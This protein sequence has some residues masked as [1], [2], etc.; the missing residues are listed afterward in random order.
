MRF[1]A[2]PAVR[3][4]ERL[5][6]AGCNPKPVLF[7]LRQELVEPTFIST[8]LS[9]PFLSILP[10][11]KLEASLQIPAG[12]LLSLSNCRQPALG[13]G[14]RALG[15]GLWECLSVDATHMVCVVGVRQEGISALDLEEG[16]AGR[17]E[18]V[19]CPLV[20][21]CLALY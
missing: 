3:R 6:T 20:D 8:N 4:L 9:S 11:Y 12:H 21:I 1:I 19:G 18:C 17:R 14:L 10:L 15:S 5:A 2:L 7:T 16:G 13:F